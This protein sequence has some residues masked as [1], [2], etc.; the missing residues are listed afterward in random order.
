MLQP[1]AMHLDAGAGPRCN[2]GPAE[3]R[4]RRRL[5]W[6]LTIASLA[7]AAGLVAA[8]VPHLVRAVLWPVAAA[9]SVTW[10][11]VVRRFCVRFGLAG[12]EN[13]GAIG[14][15][16]RVGDRQVE[17]DQRRATQLIGEGVLAGLLATVALINLP[18]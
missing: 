14:Q 8:G 17:A 5:A 15:E 2:I 7:I 12:L 13:L 16:R 11:Q 9:A 6:L 4:R 18:L 1:M 10:L 3:I